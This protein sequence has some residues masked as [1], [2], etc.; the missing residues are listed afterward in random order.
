MMM[1]FHKINHSAT[2]TGLFLFGPTFLPIRIPYGD[3]DDQREE[4]RRVKSPAEQWEPRLAAPSGV[5]SQ[6]LIFHVK[7]GKINK[8]DKQKDRLFFVLDERACLMGYSGKSIL[9][10]LVFPVSPGEKNPQ[11]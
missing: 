4:R 8:M 5:R 1:I 11:S 2:P 9:A 7:Q 10:R 3:E 6:K